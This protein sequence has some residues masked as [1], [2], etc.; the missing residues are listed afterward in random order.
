MLFE[1]EEV[2]ERL[3]SEMKKTRDAFEKHLRV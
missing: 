2:C 3:F 1:Y